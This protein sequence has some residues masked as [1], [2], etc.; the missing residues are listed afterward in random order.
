M[1]Q[2]R[3]SGEAKGGDGAL[4]L[5]A[6]ELGKVLQGRRRGEGEGRG[7]AQTTAPSGEKACDK[8]EKGKDSVGW[9]GFKEEV[10]Q[11]QASH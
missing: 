10:K 8:S 3:A 1:G 11:R 6:S 4:S 7:G 9:K 2:G 5:E